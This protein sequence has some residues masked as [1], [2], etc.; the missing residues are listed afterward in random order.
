MSSRQICD[1]GEPGVLAELC[2]KVEF[3]NLADNLISDWEAIGQL[4]LGLKQLKRLDLRYV[5]N[6]SES[7]YLSSV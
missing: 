5:Y 4:C 7:L 6:C 2:P 3:L 1:L